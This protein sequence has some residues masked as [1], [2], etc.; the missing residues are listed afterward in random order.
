MSESTSQ[1]YQERLKRFNDAVSLRKPDRVPIA[2]LAAFFMTHYAGL[3]KKEAMYDYEK[4]AS[5]WLESSRRL[6]WD[7]AV[8]S[9]QIWPAR[10]LEIMGC[11]Q[12]KWPGY[13]LPNNLTYQWVE[14][15]YMSADEYDEFLS[16]PGD[17]TFRKLWPRMGSAFEPFGMLPPLH[18][19]P[20]SYT[21]MI[22]GAVPGA[23]PVADA[24]QRLVRYG[25]DIN[26]WAGVQARL[27]QDLEAAG[28]PI[29]TF[30]FAEAPFDWVTDMLRGLKGIMLDMYRCPDKLLAAIDLF[31]DMH[32]AMAVGGAQQSGN[33]RVFIPLHRGA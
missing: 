6:N 9:F 23:P 21:M 8:P 30:A 25:E 1:L 22:F 5:A 18:W 32:I 24:F 4:M 2:S 16:N 29:L 20:S 7:L 3:D 19:M 15:E 12:F 13:N 26:R 28:Y 27:M 17:F 11:K 10:A 33:P 14:A 31:T